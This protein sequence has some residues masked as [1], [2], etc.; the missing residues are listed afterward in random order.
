M[1]AANMP[2]MLPLQ[3]VGLPFNITASMSACF[4][5]VDRSEGPQ[6]MR[7]LPSHRGLSRGASLLLV[8]AV[9]A[10]CSAFGPQRAAVPVQASPE[11]QAT[12]VTAA[13]PGSLA[14]APAASSA[15]LS[16][17]STVIRTVAQMAKPAVVQITDEQV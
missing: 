7:F 6:M 16:D 17:F 10:G 15:P 9:L 3:V 13:G 1:A 5:G 8:V 12:E 2:F 11:P 4:P 14:A